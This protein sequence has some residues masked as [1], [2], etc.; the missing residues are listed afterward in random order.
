MGEC[1]LGGGANKELTQISQGKITS[2]M[3]YGYDF[4]TS[5]VSA[6]TCNVPGGSTDVYYVLISAAQ[7]QGFAPLF[8]KAKLDT[9]YTYSNYGGRVITFKVTLSS[10]VLTLS[11]KASAAFNGQAEFILLYTT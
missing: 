2:Y 6:A 9:E 1:Y 3:T 11:V 8:V 4:Y 5:Y 7:N 10:G